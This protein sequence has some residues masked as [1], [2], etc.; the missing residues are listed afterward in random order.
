MISVVTGRSWSI[1]SFTRRSISR[2]SSRGHGAGQVEIETEPVGGHEAAL[3]VHLLA[4]DVLEGA[5]QQ[6]GRAVIAHNRLAARDVHLGADLRPHAQ[7]ALDHL[8][9]VDDQAGNRALGI[10]HLERPGRCAITPW[11]PIWPPASA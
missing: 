3:L 2:S 10:E 1:Q 11:S 5:V 9:V 7:V 4:E 8:A 6:M